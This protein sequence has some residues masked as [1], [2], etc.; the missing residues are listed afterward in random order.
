MLYR[1]LLA[2]F[3]I[4]LLSLAGCGSIAKS[5]KESALEAALG[6]YG[7]SIRW[8]YFDTAH[9]FIHPDQRKELPKHLDNIR[10]TNY[11]VVQGPLTK[12]ET[13]VEQVV[14]IQYIHRDRQMVRSLLDRQ[15]WRYEKEANAWWL[16]SGFPQFD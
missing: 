16:Y 9:S 6:M 5:K 7:D 8:G 10:V 3:S 1:T 13:S 14:R 4:V 2:V 15:L 11:Q 12:D